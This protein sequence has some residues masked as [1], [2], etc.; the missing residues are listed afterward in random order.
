MQTESSYE[1]MVLKEL[2][3]IP[4]EVLPQVIKLLKSLKHAI[5]AAQTA[6]KQ[7]KNGENSGLCGAWH[8]DRSADEIIDD[9][10]LHRS[11][12]GGRQVSL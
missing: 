11:G 12:Y 7:Q 4:G 6:Q 1:E 5:L 10:R 9:I 2:R 8:D 3:D